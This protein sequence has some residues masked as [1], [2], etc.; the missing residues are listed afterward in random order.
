MDLADTEW[1]GEEGGFTHLQEGGQPCQHL[2]FS[3]VRPTAEDSA[4]PCGT[5]TSDSHDSE[6][7]NG[8]G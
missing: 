4:K 7:I 2:D 1:A 6:I 8:G 3:L 5:Q